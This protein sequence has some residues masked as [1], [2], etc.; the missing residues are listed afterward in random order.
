MVDVLTVHPH[1]TSEV[2]VLTDEDVTFAYTGVLRE[3]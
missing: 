1:V 3:A 2:G